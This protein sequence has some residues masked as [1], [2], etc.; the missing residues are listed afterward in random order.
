MAPLGVRCTR[1]VRD[2]RCFPGHLSQKA[3]ANVA[4]AR[5]SK[6]ITA[7]LLIF[8]ED[9]AKMRRII[10]LTPFLNTPED[11]GRRGHASATGAGASAHRESVNF[12]YKRESRTKIA[13]NLQKDGPHDGQ[14]LA[15]TP[16]RNLHRAFRR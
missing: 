11:E 5:A 15:A 6:A 16:S 7:G 1:R 14:S 4:S 10:L 12:V 13:G 9:F 8:H 2:S 3:T